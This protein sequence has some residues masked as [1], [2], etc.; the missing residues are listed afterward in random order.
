M[1]VIVRIST[2]LKA[3]LA[4]M[5]SR[6]AIVVTL[7]S[8][9]SS[10]GMAST[11]RKDYR[12]SCQLLQDLGLIDKGE[13][14]RMPDHR[15]QYDDLEPLGIRFFRTLVTNAKLSNLTIPKTFFGRSK[16]S[17]VS[18][19]NCDL[20]ESTLCWNDFIEVDFSRSALTQSDLRASMYVKVLFDQA[21]LRGVDLRL[22]S[23]EACSFVGANMTNALANLKQQVSL[24]LS[25]AQR[26]QMYWTADEGE[27]PGGG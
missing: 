2:S 24:P 22:S 3:P 16:I 5:P 21:D 14:P 18:F 13:P 23:F 25:A 1:P 15:P 11:K 20:S 7:L 19:E 4:V 17:K 12:A 10:V 27:E 6:R 9:L 26:A 8:C